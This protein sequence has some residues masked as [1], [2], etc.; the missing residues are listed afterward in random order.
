L[1]NPVSQNSA[2]LFYRRIKPE[3]WEEYASRKLLE[4][5]FYISPKESGLSVFD[6]L[7]ATPDDTLNHL[8]DTWRSIAL[9]DA[10]GYAYANPRLNKC[11]SS[12]DGLKNLQWGVI[13]IHESVFQTLSL[14]TNVPRD[15]FGHLIIRGKQSDF[16]DYAPYLV[17]NNVDAYL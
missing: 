4:I 16:V 12:V 1:P 3:W 14:D 13:A 11:G 8:L 15:Q 2:R 7:L 9:R 6:S 17:R 10:K 5:A